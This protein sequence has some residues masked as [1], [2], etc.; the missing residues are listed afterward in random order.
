[1]L[2]TWHVLLKRSPPKHTPQ[3]SQ[4]ALIRRSAGPSFHTESC[5]L[6]VPSKLKYNCMYIYR[7]TSTGSSTLPACY[8][9]HYILATVISEFSKKKKPSEPA[10]PTQI[11][12]RVLLL[13][14]G[15][16][17]QDGLGKPRVRRRVTFILIY[18]FINSFFY[19]LKKNSASQSLFLDH[20][21]QCGAPLNKVNI[22]FVS[23]LLNKVNVI[24][25]SAFFSF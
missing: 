7:I 1:M 20:T 3:I 23:T 24:F 13:R 9:L 8:D 15:P 17:C 21:N 6:V 14:E 19:I 18:L 2:P 5:R 10:T 22:I 12:L 16:Q 11:F 25:V 4:C